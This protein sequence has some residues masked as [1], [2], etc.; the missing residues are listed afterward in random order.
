[1]VILDVK[2]W[3]NSTFKMLVRA[4][5]LKKPLNTLN[6]SNINLC[7]FILNEKE[8]KCLA[9][10]ELILKGFSKATKQICTET[11]LTIAYVILYYNI[12]LSRL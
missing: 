3:W 8:W 7:P 1:M 2:I 4:K 5:E 9:E 11:Y 12:L 10:I 6:N